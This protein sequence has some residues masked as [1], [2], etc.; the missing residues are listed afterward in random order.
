MFNIN[1]LAIQ[2]HK[3]NN[4]FFSGQ[5]FIRLQSSKMSGSVIY[6]IL[7]LEYIK[8]IICNL[9]KNELLDLIPFFSVSERERETCGHPICF[10]GTKGL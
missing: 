7:P 8:L 9:I 2:M 3:I 6:G 5:I 4:L 10:H 1:G